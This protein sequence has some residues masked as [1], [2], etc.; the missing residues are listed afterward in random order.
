M[1][2]GFRQG[3]PRRSSY[4][5]D[6]LAILSFVAFVALGVVILYAWFA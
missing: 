3:P 1:R 5:E 4:L 6:A 2:T